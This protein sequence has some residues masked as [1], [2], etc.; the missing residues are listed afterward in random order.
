MC[1]YLFFSSQRASPRSDTEGRRNPHAGKQGII[2][3]EGNACQRWCRQQI[4]TVHRVT[5]RRTRLKLLSSCTQYLSYAPSVFTIC[6]LIF[7]QLCLGCLFLGSQEWKS[8]F[9][10]LFLIQQMFYCM[11]MVRKMSSFRYERKQ[12]LD[13]LRTLK[14]NLQWRYITAFNWHLKSVI[15]APREVSTVLL[16]GMWVIGNFLIECFGFLFFF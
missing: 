7:V 12:N 2:Q 14:P 1:L 6:T 9:C 10:V 16:Q 8:K 11:P 3:K 4:A 15:S 5:K 13:D